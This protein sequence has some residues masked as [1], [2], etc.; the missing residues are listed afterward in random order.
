MASPLMRTIETASFVF[1]KALQR[2]DVPFLLIPM[3]QEIANQPCDIG[4]PPDELKGLVQETLAKEDMPFD[5]AKIDYSLVT[6]GWNNKVVLVGARVFNSAVLTQRAARDLRS[7]S[8][9]SREA[10][11]CASCMAVEATGGKDRAGVTWGVLALL[12]RRLE[13]LRW[14][15]GH[16]VREL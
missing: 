10:G 14:S 1:G 7:E 3:A 16:G 8:V 9:G 6:E 5:A 13:V 2:P 11:S 12:L 15:K 4:Y